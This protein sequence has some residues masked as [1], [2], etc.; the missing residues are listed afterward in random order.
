MHYINWFWVA[1]GLFF[2]GLVMSIVSGFFVD[3]SQAVC[4]I[5]GV[6]FNIAGWISFVIGMI[7]R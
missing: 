4:V 5:T 3:V 1:A 7:K 6:L 2:A